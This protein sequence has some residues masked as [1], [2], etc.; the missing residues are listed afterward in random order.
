[1]TGPTAHLVPQS[2]LL[3][4]ASLYA[5]PAL[6]LWGKGGE[7]A[8]G[9]YES[10][11]DFGIGLADISALSSDSLGGQGA[12]VRWG[13]R[14]Q[15]TFKFDRIEA[16]VR[17][18]LKS[19]LLTFP[20]LVSRA[21]T[22]LRSAVPQLRFTT[23]VIEV[24]VHSTL[25]GATAS[26]VLSGLGVRPLEIPAV[27]RSHGAIYHFNYPEKSARVDLLIDHSLT[28]SGGIYLHFGVVTEGDE[29]DYA[30]TLLWGEQTMR[31]ILAATGLYFK[32]DI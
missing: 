29:I 28:I 14:S 27:S 24:S 12:V 5:Q 13:D 2:N 17:N 31:S 18:Y 23:R 8:A 9:L 25:A 6:A 26:E 30:G 10:F 11:H 22:W 3:S 16:N 32:E 15:M 4:Y 1:L 7:I 19:D 20:V 21:E